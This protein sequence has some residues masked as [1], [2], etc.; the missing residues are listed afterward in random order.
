[1]ADCP[2]R[3]PVAGLIIGD[4]GMVDVHDQ[5][6]RDV[7][8]VRPSYEGMLAE[9]MVL[10]NQAAFWRHELHQQLRYLRE[11]LHF[12]LDF[13]WFLRILKSSILAAHV[14]GMRGAAYA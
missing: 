10:M 4:I 9:G 7:K 3:K 8:Y 1:M 12:G 13:E 2:S 11:D 6:L 5:V 14:R